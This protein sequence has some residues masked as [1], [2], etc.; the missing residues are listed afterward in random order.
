V[1]KVTFDRIKTDA[2]NYGL[3]S[4]AVIFRSVLGTSR[5]LSQADFGIAF[6]F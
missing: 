2:G 1:K 5:F 4:F 3:F 6:G